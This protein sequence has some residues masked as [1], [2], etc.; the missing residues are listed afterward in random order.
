MD[1]WT[2]L[3]WGMAL[4][5]VFGVG[6]LIALFVFAPAL[7][8]VILN[9]AVTIVGDILKTRL[10]VAVLVGAACLVAGELAGDYH[11]RSVAEAAC[12]A[13]QERADAEAVARD[14]QQGALADQ[15]AKKRIAV[16]E[17]AAKKNQE[18]IN[19]YTKALGKRKSAVCALGA[20]DL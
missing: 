7:A 15:D 4:I 8:Q 5:G 18:K 6:G 20:G 1:F 9:G 14:K 2:V 19:A 17:A 11:G 10:G 16:L 3:N 13:A 12:H